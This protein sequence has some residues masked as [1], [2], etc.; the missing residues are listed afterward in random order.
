MSDDRFN[1]LLE[2]ASAVFE[3]GEGA[4]REIGASIAVFGVSETVERL[5]A[6]A[7]RF[8]TVKD[9][10]EDKLSKLSEAISAMSSGGKS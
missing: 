4:V 3:D 8:G 2:E 6:G 1:R 5:E 7:E 10:S 9:K